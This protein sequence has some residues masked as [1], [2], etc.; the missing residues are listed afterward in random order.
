MNLVFRHGHAEFEAYVR[1][2][3]KAQWEILTIMIRYK[4][5]TKTQ[6]LDCELFE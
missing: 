2:G 6:L 1:L 5:K 3:R 4:K